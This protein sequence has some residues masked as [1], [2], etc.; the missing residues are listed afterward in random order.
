MV[1]PLSST[2]VLSVAEPS[3]P[4]S[5][6]LRRS[7][8]VEVLVDC[9]GASGFYTYKLPIDLPVHIG[10][11]LSVPFGAQQVGAIAIRF[12][13]VLPLD[14]D[15]EQIREVEAIV[16]AGFFPA[17]YW[18][19]LSRVADYYHTSLM[20]VVKVALPPGLLTRSQRRIRLRKDAALAD[21]FLTAPAQQILNVLR[22][23]KTGDY[24]WR[25]VQRQVQT[26]N[27]GLQELLKWQLVESY[28]EPPKP[29]R[30]K[31]KQAVTLVKT[32]FLSDLSDLT[33]RQREILEL[34]KRQGGETWL[35]ELLQMGHTSS[36]VLKKLESKGYVVIQLREVLRA[37][38]S[39]PAEAEGARIL[40]PEQT[41]ALSQIRQQSRFIQILLH[42]VTGSGKTEVYLQAI[43]PI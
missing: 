39:G 35:N 40:T 28:L 29:V 42:G 23:S 5:T 19:L 11:I 14:L 33:D 10:D 4:Y 7:E 27:R 17:S 30:P 1:E 13:E 16:S 12:L 6:D 43:A 9:P 37:E 8:W 41:E 21:P 38:Q 15:P 26:A 22:A 32:D 31:A 18:S 2:L 34:L 20:Q 25:F 3:A 36:P 24:S